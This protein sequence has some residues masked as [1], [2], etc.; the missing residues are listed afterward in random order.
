MKNKK[1]IIVGGDSFIGKKLISFFQRKKITFLATSK[2]KRKQKNFIYFN[3]KSKNNF[4][5]KYQP[6]YII[7]CAGITNINFCQKNK[8]FS[9]KI[10][11]DYAKL[12]FYEC[13]KRNIHIIY[14]STD[15][16]YKSKNLN[17]KINEYGKQK[18]IIEKF[19]KKK[20]KLYTILRLGKIIHNKLSLYAKWRKQLADGLP[21]EVFSNYYYYNT[22]IKDLL[23]TVYSVVTKKNNFRIINLYDKKRFSYVDLANSFLKKTSK[24]FLKKV[25]FNF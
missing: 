24:T 8:K 17:N 3:L 15:K 20:S 23:I 12:F 4:L 1:I 22:S 9:R 6:T 18:I 2:K 13:I 10:N 14:F 19:L 11:I 5:N 7:F 16:V 21:I 25:Y